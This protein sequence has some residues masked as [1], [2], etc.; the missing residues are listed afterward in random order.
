M[1]RRVQH[2][3]QDAFEGHQR[4]S[5]EYRRL[6]LALFAAGF[7]TFAQIFDAQAVLPALAADLDVAPHLR[8][9]G[10]VTNYVAGFCLL[11]A[12]TTVY[13]YLG[14]RLMGRPFDVPVEWVSLLFVVYLFGTVASRRSGPAAQRHG[15]VPVVLVGV[16]LVVVAVPPMLTGSLPVVVAG[17]AVFTVGI[18][19]AHPVCSALSGQRA[20]VGRAQS[21]ALYQLSWLSGT[22]LTGWASGHVYEDLGWSATLD[23]VVVLALV[24]AAAVVLGSGRDDWRGT[25]PPSTVRR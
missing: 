8:T 23:L 10:L 3:P 22:A 24:A 25:A 16:A 7:A 1:I 12:F 4:G 5:G 18:F 20:V 14:F 17:A 9:R 19:C 13:N 21:T 15:P 2:G 11:G 6:L